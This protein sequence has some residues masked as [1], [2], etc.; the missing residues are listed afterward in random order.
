MPLLRNDDLVR[1]DLPAEGEWVEVKRRLGRGD[2]VAV[3]KAIMTGLKLPAEIITRL[4]EPGLTAAKLGEAVMSQGIDAATF[5]EGAQ[6]ATLEVAIKAWSFDDEVTPE[7]IRELDGESIDVIVARLNDL[8][9]GPRTDDDRKNSS[10]SGRAPSS[11]EA[12]P[13]VN[14]DGSR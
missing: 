8:Y 14:S 9:P 7:G 4:A 2:E 10:A 11:A 12:S 13:P 3:Q 1:I 5:L 6:F